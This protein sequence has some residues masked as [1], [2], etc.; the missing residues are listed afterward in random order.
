MGE[1]VEQALHILRR[2]RGGD[3]PVVP[4]PHVHCQVHQR[5]FLVIPLKAQSIHIVV[6]TLIQLGVERG[7]NPVG[8]WWRIGD[9]GAGCFYRPRSASEACLPHEQMQTVMP[10]VQGLSFWMTI[11]RSEAA[12]SI[13]ICSAIRIPR[14]LSPIYAESGSP[15]RIRFYVPHLASGE[16]AHLQ[17]GPFQTQLPQQQLKILAEARIFLVGND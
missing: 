11:W 13:S 12:L 2:L 7:L 3:T 10:S 1:K 17:D 14:I 5:Q 9:D 6:H 16:T 4:S 8:S 15:T